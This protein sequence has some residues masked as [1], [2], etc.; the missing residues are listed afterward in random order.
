MDYFPLAVKL[1]HKRVI[2]VGGGCIALRKTNS[3]LEAG[4]QVYI[5]SPKLKSQLHSLVKQGSVFWLNRCV[6]RDD[7]KNAFFVIA[8][9]GDHSVNEKVAQWA[10]EEGILVNVVDQRDICDFIFPAVFRHQQA[11][12][13]VYTDGRAPRLSKDLKDYLKEHWDEF[14]SDRNRLQN[15]ATA[16]EGSCQ[17]A[18]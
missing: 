1:K 9:T 8:A 17:P 10:K 7:I 3:L 14:I 13:A 5:I 4:A 15:C 18:T 16:S 11:I 6:C 2:V 12:V